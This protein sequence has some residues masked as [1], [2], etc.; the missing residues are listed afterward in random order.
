MDG[1]RGRAG[2]WVTGDTPPEPGTVPLIGGWYEPEFGG[3]LTLPAVITA[4]HP[5]TH[6]R[7]FA[8]IRGLKNRP[9]R[10]S[11]GVAA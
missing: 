4:R 6:S 9:G 10:Q 7:P 5:S 11:Q 1:M 8:F 3:S 2:V